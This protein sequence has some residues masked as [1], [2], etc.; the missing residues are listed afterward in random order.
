MEGVKRGEIVLHS[1]ADFAGA[2]EVDFV[3]G[4]AIDPEQGAGDDSAIEKVAVAA[5]GAE[6]EGHGAGFGVPGFV[7]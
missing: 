6:L 4:D 1:G 3:A 5:A 7:G 2:G